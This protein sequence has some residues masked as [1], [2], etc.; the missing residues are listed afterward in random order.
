VLRYLSTNLT[1]RE[2]AD[3]LYVSVHTVNTHVRVSNG[4]DN[5]HDI[6]AVAA[7]KDDSSSARVHGQLP[8][9]VHVEQ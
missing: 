9:C 7:A 4:D 1:C 6:A 2:I 5:H 8:T 3:E